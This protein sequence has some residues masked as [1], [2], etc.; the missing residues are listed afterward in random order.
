MWNKESKSSL[1]FDLNTIHGKIDK[2]HK[3]EQIKCD[4]MVVRID[5]VYWYDAMWWWETREEGGHIIHNWLVN[6]GIGTHGH[7]NSIDSI[8][9]HTRCLIETYRWL[10]GHSISGRS[11]AKMVEGDNILYIQRQHFIDSFSSSLFVSLIHPRSFSVLLSSSSSPT[12]N[13]I[14][15]HIVWHK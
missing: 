14:H 13:V 2:I 11:L 15:V 1:S 3:N 9:F 10:V 6:L 12:S 4:K 7:I 5:Y 8:F